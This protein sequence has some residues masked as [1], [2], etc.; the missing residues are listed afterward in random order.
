MKKFFAVLLIALC[1]LSL[2]ACGGKDTDA[3]KDADTGEESLIRDCTFT[4]R[5]L[6][7]HEEYLLVEP[8]EDSVER[9]SYDKLKVTLGELSVPEG[10]KTGDTLRIVYNSMVQE[11]YP[12]IIP[13]AS[14][15]EKVN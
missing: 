11:L 6:E 12:A 7:I 4:A 9:Q 2:F 13:Y 15:I 1:A 8:S 14:V 3:G 10:L 5:V